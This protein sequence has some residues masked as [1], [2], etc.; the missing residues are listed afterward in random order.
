MRDIHARIIATPTC[1]PS[2]GHVRWDPV[3]SIWWTGMT[4]AWI[5]GGTIWFSG[6]AVV[7]FFVA[8]TVILC[9]GHSIGMHRRLIHE[10]FNCPHWLTLIGVWLGTLVGLGGPRTMMHS[11]DLRDWAQRQPACHPYLSQSHRPLRDFWWQIHGRLRLD[12]PPEFEASALYRECRVMQFLQA[13]SFFQQI[14]VAYLL[15]VV[16]GPGFVAWAVCGRI[17]VSIFGHWA[18]GWVAHNQGHRDFHNDGH[19]TQGHNVRGFG[20]ITFGEAYHNNHHAFPESARLGLFPDQ[21]D[22]GWWVLRGLQK[23]GLVWDVIE[24]DMTDIKNMTQARL[25][26]P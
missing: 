22:P 10:S 20:L 25:S 7:A 23:I 11:H 24:P 17:S 5:I 9:G 12:H 3:K 15:W 6:G 2:A 1:N 19:S 16:G 14:P 21:P 8:C 13:T 26:H 18:V 4:V